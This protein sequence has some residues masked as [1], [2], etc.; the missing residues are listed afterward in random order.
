MIAQK[1]VTE[2]KS[3][4]VESLKKHTFANREFPTIVVQ[5][6]NNWKIW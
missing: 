4:Y 5:S 6:S 2:N 3:E 1:I